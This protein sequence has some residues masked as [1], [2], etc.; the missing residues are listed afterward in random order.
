MSQDPKPTELKK[1]KTNNTKHK[2]SW[3]DWLHGYISSLE[4]HTAAQSFEQQCQLRGCG[5]LHV[6]WK[7]HSVDKC[8][9]IQID[10][11]QKGSWSCKYLKKQNQ[12]VSLSKF[13]KS[14]H[15]N[16]VTFA[17][18]KHSVILP[19]WQETMCELFVRNTD[20]ILEC[21]YLVDP[22]FWHSPLWCLKCK[23]AHYNVLKVGQQ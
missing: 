9:I 13:G 19:L 5:R 6:N 3:K 23:M 20:C 1:A 22:L 17:Y 7:I 15:D 14:L 12:T 16:K 18:F 8:C 2:E 4:N 21:D 11:A 10:L